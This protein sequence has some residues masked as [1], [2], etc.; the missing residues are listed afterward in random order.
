MIRVRIGNDVRIRWA[1]FKADGVTPEDFSDVLTLAVSIR[2]I[3]PQWEQFQEVTVD[4]NI[5]SIDFIA[6]EQRHLGTHDLKVRFTREDPNVEG[7]ISTF[8]VDNIGAFEL[9]RHSTMLQ[10]SAEV[11]VD[12]IVSGLSYD[13]LTESQKIDIINRLVASGFLVRI[14]VVDDLPDVGVP[15]EYYATFVDNFRPGAVINVVSSLP[16][17]GNPD[18]FYATFED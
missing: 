12:G 18:E 5:I 4:D 15:G 7:Q 14:N 13:M 17:E 8:T 3:N 1:I 10:P 9:V 6:S 2:T 11:N 16:D